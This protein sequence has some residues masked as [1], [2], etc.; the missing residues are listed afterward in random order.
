MPQPNFAISLINKCLVRLGLV[1]IAAIGLSPNA[2]AQ[3]VGNGDTVVTPNGNQFAIDSSTTIGPNQFFSFDQFSVNAAQTAIFQNRDNITNALAKVSGGSPSYISG[4][5]QFL[6]GSPNLYLMNPAGILFGSNAQLDLRGGF[7]ATTA[8]G[9]GFGNTWW[10]V[11]TGF[12][13]QIVD[14]LDHP[15]VLRFSP[16]MPGAIVNLGN[17]SVPYGQALS[18]IGGTVISTGSLSAPSGK[19]NIASVPSDRLVQLSLPGSL[20]GIAV[21]RQA[22][23]ALGFNPLTIPALITGAGSPDANQLVINPN[24]SIQ[25]K[26]TKALNMTDNTSNRDVA[27]QA[28]DVYFQQF[29]DANNLAER[30]AIQSQGYLYGHDLTVIDTSGIA[31]ISLIGELG[32]DVNSISTIS[33]DKNTIDGNISLVS[34]QGS[35]IVSTII[36]KTGGILI[37]ANQKFQAVGITTGSG[38]EMVPISLRSL[39]GVT[40]EHA[41]PDVADSNPLE[42]NQKWQINPLDIQGN[43]E[44]FLIGPNQ[45]NGVFSRKI[46]PDNVSGT[47]G[48][49]EI[50]IPAKNGFDPNNEAPI[51]YRDLSFGTSTPPG[52]V[53]PPLIDMPPNPGEP[54]VLPPNQGSIL[55]SSSEGVNNPVPSINNRLG[56]L[57]RPIGESC[58]GAIAGAGGNR[59]CASNQSAPKSEDSALIEDES[60][61]QL[62]TPKTVQ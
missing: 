54:S 41:N 46:L 2:D 31:N 5:I 16:G 23:P 15:T 33:T 45:V 38:L 34:S 60:L 27:V 29:G 18:L 42:Q 57:D 61:T 44:I 17:I 13:N 28:G 62:L 11:Q 6:N 51:V 26:V 8:S 49:I 24:G 9:I 39:K 36:N 47:A 40:I 21:P 43:G 58:Q 37:N 12:G 55:P 30:L 14:I 32:I 25:L 20:L 50:R 3:I 4:Q 52:E 48:A 59:N 19:I 22:V 56:T 7:V 10:D 53:L 35:V 1:T